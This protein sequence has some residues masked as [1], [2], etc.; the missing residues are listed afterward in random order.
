MAKSS[1][2]SKP[3]KAAGPAKAAVKKTKAGSNVKG[4][5]YG[6]SGKAASGATKSAAS[7]KK[8][9]PRSSSKAATAP[10]ST[11]IRRDYMKSLL[12]DY[13]QQDSQ[14]KPRTKAKSR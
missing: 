1:N 7:A 2:K 10:V 11:D 9:A 8:T 13:L 3:K 12:G 5:A 4:S 6:K 14:E